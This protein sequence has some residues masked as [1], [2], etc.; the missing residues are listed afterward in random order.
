MC[1]REN[2]CG[3][4][5]WVEEEGRSATLKYH[6]KNGVLNGR[7]IDF[8]SRQQLDDESRGTTEAKS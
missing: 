4:V 7:P 2:A 3:C 6:C 5:W 1:E 8:Y